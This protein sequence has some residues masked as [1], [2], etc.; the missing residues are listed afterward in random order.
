VIDIDISHA[1]G[2]RTDTL[3]PI[4]AFQGIEAAIFVALAVVAV[5]LTFCTVF[6]TRRVGLAA[7][8]G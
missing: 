3:V 1:P 5:V 6:E 7:V 2:R 4:W 8:Q